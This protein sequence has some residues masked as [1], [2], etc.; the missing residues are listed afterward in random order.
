MIV[1]FTVF[2]AIGLMLRK[3]ID[4][5]LT[6]NGRTEVIVKSEGLLGEL[7]IT[8][9]LMKAPDGSPFYARK[10]HVNNIAQNYVFR[11]APQFSLLYYVNFTRHLLNALPPKKSALLVGLGAG[12]LYAILKNQGMHVETVEI[13]QRMYDFGVKYFQMP[14]H[15][16]H[17]ITDGRYFV[18]TTRKK[19]DLMIL[20]VIIGENVAGQLLTQESFKKV[21]DFLDKDGILIV[22]H[23]GLTD[24]AGNQ[25]IPSVIKTL[26]SVGFQVRLFNP[27]MSDKFGDVLFLATKQKLSFIKD[28][29]P[30][31]FL[32]KGRS[33][34]EAELPVDRFEHK[35]ATILTDDKN[36]SDLLLKS[37]Y[38]QIRE[39]FRNYLTKTSKS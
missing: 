4:D 16:D 35:T 12:S 25:L 27:L 19:Y 28:T 9:E 5:S 26:K 15:E 3:G 38:F 10:L 2:G 14:P 30:G 22:E 13:D 32:M 23:G 8:D 20:D 18:N 36:N 21:Y 33:F 7:K 34:K 37:H 31:D 6:D 29:F 1:A 39:N 24:I 17:T 11:D